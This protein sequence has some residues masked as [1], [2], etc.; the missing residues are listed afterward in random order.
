MNENQIGKLNLLILRFKEHMEQMNFSPRTVADYPQQ[1][2][3]FVEYLKTTDIAD[4]NNITKETVHRYQVHLYN[5]KNKR[6]NALSLGTQYSRLVCLKSLFKF[7]VKQGYFLYDPTSTVELPKCKRDLPKGI[8]TRKEVNHLLS[9]P[10]ADTPLGLR[11]KAILEVLYS[12][13]MRNAELR[14]LTIYDVDTVN[15]EVRITNGKGG[16]DR[17]LPVGEIASKYVEAYLKTARQLLVD[18]AENILKKEKAETNTLFI[19]KGAKKI[20]PG[21]LIDLT[22]KYVKKAGVEKQITP[23]CVRHT[24]AT[25][26][27][28]CGANIRHIQELLA[29]AQ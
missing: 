27:L 16:K 4:I 28:K 29:M 7:L 3:F 13:G 6:G 12:T 8:M 20:T 10:D 19:S 26:M 23:H 14:A 9:Q 1:L 2:N 22:K 24:C 21:N 15:H 25:H 17:V 5:Y 18:Y 11:D